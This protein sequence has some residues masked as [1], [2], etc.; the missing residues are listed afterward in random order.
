MKILYFFLLTFNFCLSAWSAD[1]LP[2]LE[3]TDI[4]TKESTSAPLAS[5]PVSIDASAIGPIRVR[6]ESDLV[7]AGEVLRA[8][9]WFGGKLLA[10]WG[11]VIGDLNSQKQPQ[12]G[13]GV[14]IKASEFAGKNIEVKVAPTEG[15][16][17]ILGATIELFK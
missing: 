4:I 7:Y 10:S 12:T 1:V 13:C 3:K 2:Q 14:I 9:I 5:G 11:C 17:M 16:P 6:G 8:E 15:K